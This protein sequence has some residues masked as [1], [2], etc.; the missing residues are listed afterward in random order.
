MQAHREKENVLETLGIGNTSLC[1]PFTVAG[2]DIFGRESEST[3][4]R[5]VGH[6]GPCLYNGEGSDFVSRPY[7]EVMKYE[8]KNKSEEVSK[9]ERKS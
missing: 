5:H 4:A 1:R 7:C 8:S 3:I 9:S 6:P 2:C